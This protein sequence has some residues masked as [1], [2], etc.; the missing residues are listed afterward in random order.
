MSSWRVRRAGE[1]IFLR[2]E[3]TETWVFPDVTNLR[4]S[5][6]LGFSIPKLQKQRPL[7]TGL[8]YRSVMA[9]KSIKTT[10]PKRTRAEISGLYGTNFLRLTG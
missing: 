2:L 4:N 5:P 9:Q 3:E 7:R 10:Q 8:R 1:S 6:F